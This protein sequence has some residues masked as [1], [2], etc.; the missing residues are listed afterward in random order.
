[1]KLVN[2]HLKKDPQRIY[3]GI[4]LSDALFL[5][6]ERT[7]LTDAE[8]K[9]TVDLEQGEAWGNDSVRIERVR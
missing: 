2:L 1:M 9:R 7:T 8:I 3:T 4:R 6:L 5:V